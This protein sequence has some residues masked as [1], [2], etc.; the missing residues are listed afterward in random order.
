MSEVYQDLYRVL[1]N[2]MRTG[3][4][5]APDSPHA[6]VRLHNDG[7]GWTRERQQLHRAV[8]DDFKAK[9]GDRPR[10]GRAV[11]L[12]A[13]APGA[14]KGSAQSNLET[15]Q[16]QDSELGRSL[17]AAHGV[18]LDHYVPLDPD[19]FKVAIFKH[20]GLPRLGPELT[21]LPHGRELAP[22]EMASLI[23][24]ESSRLQDT[25][26]RW[27]RREGYNLLY[28]ATL[29]NLDKNAVLLDQLGKGGYEQRVI[30]SVEVP[31][32]QCLAQNAERW[33]RGRVNYEAGRDPDHYGGRMAPEAMIKGL[34]AQGDAARGYSIGRENAEKLAERGLAT[35]LITTDRGTFPQAATK[36][37]VPA[38]GQGQGQGPA[39]AQAPAFQQGDTRVSVSVAAAGRLRSS[40]TGAAPATPSTRT[41][42]PQVPRQNPPAPGRTR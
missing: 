19:E 3:G 30:L 35:G 15:W 25:F 8:L 14:G 33:Q 36:A 26:E 22:S 27:A 38:Q 13:G 9:Y 10:G 29:K 18:N 32:E 23:H 31:L 7:I 11:L 4:D 39:Q 21:A 2:R 1:Q 37:G 28:D 17:A 6:T 5:L 16:G 34:Y 40:R 42:A 41:T 24:E 12:T 20:G